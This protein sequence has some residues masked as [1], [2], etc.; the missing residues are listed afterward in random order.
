MKSSPFLHAGV[1]GF[2][3]ASGDGR[4]WWTRSNIRTVVEDFGHLGW[5]WAP[6]GAEVQ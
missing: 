5:S 1:S 6:G 4:E 3:N 2:F